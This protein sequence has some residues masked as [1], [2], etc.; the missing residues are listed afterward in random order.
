MTNGSDR[1]VAEDACPDCGAPSRVV[2]S[3][4]VPALGDAPRTILVTR[5]CRDE[6]CQLKFPL[7]KSEEDLA[8]DERAA[9]TRR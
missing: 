7:F 2:T 4:T 1:G 6:T 3:V 5:Q 8:Q 9:W